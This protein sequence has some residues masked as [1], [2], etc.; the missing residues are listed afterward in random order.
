MP[1]G[2]PGRGPPAPS[3]FGFCW[4]HG[5]SG[6]WTRHPSLFLW[7]RLHEASPSVSAPPNKDTSHWVRAT[8]LQRGLILTND[9]LCKGLLL[10]VGPILR[11]WVGVNSGHLLSRILA[12]LTAQPGPGRS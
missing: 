9:S 1:T 12:S 8:P 7:L 3:R 11:L 6:L 4:H 10:R 5:V 2:G